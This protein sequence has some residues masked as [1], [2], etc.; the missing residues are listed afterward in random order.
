M[1]P[2][3]LQRN[4][5][6]SSL[7]NASNSNPPKRPSSSRNYIS[8]STYEIIKK[9]KKNENFARPREKYRGE[10]DHLPSCRDTSNN[11]PGSV[12][13]PAS[14]TRSVQ[15]VSRQDVIHAPIASR[16]RTR[17]SVSTHQARRGMLNFT[18]SIGGRAVKLLG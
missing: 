14:E 17:T 12:S 1:S 9:K 15:T 11:R 18:S 6:E 7:I 8:R 3:F 4:A 16:A 2:I 13:C 5:S 10:V